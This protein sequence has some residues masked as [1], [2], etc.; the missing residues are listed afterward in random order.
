[1]GHG[2]QSLDHVGYIH[3]RYTSPHMQESAS[4]ALQEAE[5]CRGE[6]LIVS[7]CVWEMERA[8]YIERVHLHVMHPTIKLDFEVD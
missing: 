6:Q 4:V 5:A 7:E 8:N 3:G 1:M 2:R